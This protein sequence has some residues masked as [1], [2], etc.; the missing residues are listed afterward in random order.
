[1]DHN[2]FTLRIKNQ[3]EPGDLKQILGNPHHNWHCLGFK[4]GGDF[5]IC[6]IYIYLICH[7]RRGCDVSCLVPRFVSFSEAKYRWV[8]SILWSKG[9]D[10]DVIN[11]SK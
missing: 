1:M 8:I 5:K 4:S 11:Q 9:I 3:I 10:F 7:L 2:K 6:S